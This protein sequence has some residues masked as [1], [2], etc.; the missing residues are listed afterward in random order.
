MRIR[1]WGVGL[2][3]LVLVGCGG[4]KPPRKPVTILGRVTDAK[5]KPVG[6]VMLSFAPMDAANKDERPMA[7]VASD[8]L[9][10]AD[11]LP[12]RYRVTL[13]PMPKAPG[14]A[15]DEGNVS[16]PEKAK[17]ASGKNPMEMMKGGGPSQPTWDIEVKSSGNEEFKLQVR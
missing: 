15:P 7:Q 12:G 4:G 3:A 16:A 5:G 2:V 6:N 8:G 13:I 14:Q 1:W 17:G 9:F 10:K 11:C